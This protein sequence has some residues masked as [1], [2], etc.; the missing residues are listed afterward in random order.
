M[1]MQRRIHVTLTLGQ[2]I[3][4]A[5]AIHEGSLSAANGLGEPMPDTYKDTPK[6]TKAERAVNAQRRADHT[7]HQRKQRQRWNAERKVF[8]ILMNAIRETVP[9]LSEAPEAPP[10]THQ[11]RPNT[12]GRNQ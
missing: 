2:A 6:T 10:P 4:A 1:T 3:T 7:A 9:E 8:R 11:E 12:N 5:Q